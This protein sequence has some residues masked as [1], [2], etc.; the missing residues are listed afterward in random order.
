MRIV[1]FLSRKHLKPLKLFVQVLSKALAAS[2]LR[3]GHVTVFHFQCAT[4]VVQMI[5]IQLKPISPRFLEQGTFKA[6]LM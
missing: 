4:L 1:K 3:C 5:L 6:Q 2:L